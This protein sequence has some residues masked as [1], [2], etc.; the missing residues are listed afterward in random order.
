[1]SP[2]E[3]DTVITVRL[4]ADER[5]LLAKHA[6]RDGVS[7]S[8]VLRGMLLREWAERR[9][10]WAPRG[11]RIGDIE[12]RRFAPYTLLF[13]KEHGGSFMRIAGIVPL[14]LNAEIELVDPNVSVRVVRVRLLAGDPAVLCLDVVPIEI[15]EVEALPPS[16]FHGVRIEGGIEPSTRSTASKRKTK[17]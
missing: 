2:Q 12:V 8:D 4:S 14:P 1:M 17:R 16:R 5:A 6:D 9:P 3:R 15:P 11:Q 13:D 10:E 7:A